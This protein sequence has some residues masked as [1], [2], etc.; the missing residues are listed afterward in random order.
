MSAGGM[1]VGEKQFDLSASI[2]NF[3]VGLFGRRSPLPRGAQQSLPFPQSITKS[4]LTDVDRSPDVPVLVETPARPYFQMTRCHY[5]SVECSEPRPGWEIRFGGDVLPL[6]MLQLVGVIQ[7][8][9]G[10]P[11]FS[12]PL[13]IESLFE[14]LEERAGLLINFH[15]IWL[16]GFLFQRGVQTGDT[17]RIK[18]PLFREAYLF[19]GG[20]LGEREFEIYC[21]GLDDA[22][23]FSKDETTAFTAWC[24][25]QVVKAQHQEPKN[26]DLRLKRFDELE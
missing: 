1:T 13:L 23:I 21:K 2:R 14:L 7:R 8:P 9:I 17:Y 18:V 24:D 19:R 26:P 6:L 5:I 25:E 11:R 22:L 20:R 4:L 16:P 10:A 15:D 3:E 12:T